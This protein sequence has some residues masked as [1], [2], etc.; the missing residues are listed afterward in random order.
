MFINQIGLIVYF[1][2]ELSNDVQINS[3]NPY[4]KKIRVPVLYHRNNIKKV[5]KNFVLPLIS[6]NISLM[7]YNLYIQHSKI[8][9]IFNAKKHS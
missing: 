2:Y 6:T 4:K 3:T 1:C 9:Q 7:I 8:L 5:V